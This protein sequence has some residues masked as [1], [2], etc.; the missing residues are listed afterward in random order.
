MT[1]HEIHALS[2]AYAVDALDDLE[3]LRFEEHLALCAECQAEVSSLQ[4]ATLLLSD[5]TEVAPPAAMRSRLLADIKT[6]RPL[7]PLNPVTSITEKIR[8]PR[9][10]TN[11]VAAAAVL[12]VLGGGTAVWQSVS[13]DSSAPQISAA[14]QVLRARDV[15]HVTMDLA[16]GATA[17]VFR[18]DSKN[19]AVL[20]T[21]KMPKAPSGK[22]YQLW[23][24]KGGVMIPAGTLSGSGDLTYVLQGDLDNATGAGITLEDG[25]GATKPT[26]S[27]A[28]LFNFEQAT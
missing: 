16:K 2:G 15:E 6:V 11:L 14:D 10:W 24:Q 3:R 28:T 25:P 18:S 8:R 5:L 19:K 27:G 23:L 9:R 22:I 26:F 12:G 17:T 13:D 20:V 21:E 4:G 1:A 7:P